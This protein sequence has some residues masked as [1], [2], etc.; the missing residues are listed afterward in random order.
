MSDDTF[1]TTRED[2]RKPESHVSHTH[3]GNVPKDSEVSVLKVSSFDSDQKSLESVQLT[4]V[5]S[6]SSIK[7]QSP[8]QK[9]SM[10]VKPIC[11]YQTNLQ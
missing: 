2:L 7:T 6:P 10:S 4:V 9:S 3:D 11:L 8:S 5:L 1:H